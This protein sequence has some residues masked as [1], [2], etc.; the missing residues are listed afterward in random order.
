M[1]RDHLSG[2]LSFPKGRSGG[3]RNGMQGAGPLRKA[4]SNQD[5]GS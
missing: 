5:E 4:G 1:L 3:R 2:A